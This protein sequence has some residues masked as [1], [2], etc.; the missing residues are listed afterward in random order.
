LTRVLLIKTSSLG[1]VIHCLP[2]VSDMAR[3]TPDL[4]LDWVIEEQLAEIA[5]LH[6]AVDRAIPVRLRS[7]RRRP[8]AGDTWT[9]FGVFRHAV[10]QKRYDRIID[11]Q[12][13]IRSALLARLARG[14]HCGYDRNSVREP[15]ASLF[16][17]RRYAASVT[18]HA[19]ERMR[20]LAAQAM[21]YEMPAEL[22]YG[23]R[24]TD[25]RSQWLSGRPYLVAL[26]ATARPD[27]TWSEDGWRD[28][29]AR[30]AAMGLDVVLPWGGEPE[31]Q[32]SK[33]I[34]AAA[35]TA[36]VPPSLGFADMAALLAGA[37]AV[38]GVD[39]GLTHLASAVGAPVV[40]IYAASWSEFN[41]VIGPSFVANLGGPGAPPSADQ[42]WAS[43]LDA[44]AYG[45]KAGS[46]SAGAAEPAPHLAGRRRFR[47]SNARAVVHRR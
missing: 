12:G 7:W 14:P 6:P 21:G 4:V 8:L 5:R 36:L 47:P 23:L 31:R 30:A 45:Q 46:W 29:V 11:A 33:R 32:R 44:V 10:R 34:A 27:K 17:D 38:V 37:A 24:I 28:L 40:A 25:A 9:E 3:E 41:G 13:L 19:A 26:H 42:V 43:T 39:T 20:R 35:P 18:I 16:Y 22:D 1:D 15:P 2:A